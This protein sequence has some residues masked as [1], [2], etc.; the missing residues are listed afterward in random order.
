MRWNIHKTITKSCAIMTIGLGTLLSGCTNYST[1][2]ADQIDLS[3]EDKNL[4]SAIK[5]ES[6]QVA[7]TFF[8]KSKISDNHNFAVLSDY[9]DLRKE[10]EEDNFNGVNKYTER[11][12]EVSQFATDVKTYN[13]DF[14]EQMQDFVKNFNA[15]YTVK[16]KPYTPLDLSRPQVG[17]TDVEVLSTFWGQPTDIN[18]TTT[19][20]GVSEQW[21]YSNNR[22][23]YLENGIVTAIQE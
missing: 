13:G 9:I 5:S 15:L 6:W 8:E 3:K 17:M 21:V 18:K 19:A 2:A 12:V 1:V 11:M 4:Y 16:N 20:S 10:I 7:D 23:V 22:Y 14:K